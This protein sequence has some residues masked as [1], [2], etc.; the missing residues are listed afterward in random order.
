MFLKKKTK[1][2][3]LISKYRLNSSIESDYYNFVTESIKYCGYKYLAVIFD[4][5]NLIINYKK[6][7]NILK[8]KKIIVLAEANIEMICTL[9]LCLI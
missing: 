9:I 5:K 2:L 8:K 6:I 4:K 7:V 1:F 3:L